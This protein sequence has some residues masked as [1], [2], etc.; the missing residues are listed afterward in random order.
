[1]AL[2]TIFT[3]FV[4][5]ALYTVFA[6]HRIQSAS[7][8]QT[9]ECE[10]DRLIRDIDPHTPIEKQHRKSGCPISH[11]QPS[12]E[13]QQG[14]RCIRYWPANGLFCPLAIRYGRPFGTDHCA[15][16]KM[17]DWHHWGEY[18]LQTGGGLSVNRITRPVPVDF[19]IF[20]RR[21]RCYELAISRLSC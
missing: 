1:M 20:L 5:P 7:A 10:S 13:K 14:T 6:T 4:V 18:N 8:N 16:Q 11:W 2:G 17:V 15:S 9:C 19:S 3:L 12:L 21:S